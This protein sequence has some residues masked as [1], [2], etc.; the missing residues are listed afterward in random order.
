MEGTL[1]ECRTPPRT[2][3]NDLAW[4]HF[5]PWRALQTEG[6][7]D[8]VNIAN[9]TNVAMLTRSTRNAAKPRRLGTQAEYSFALRLKVVKV[10]R[11]TPSFVR[12]EWRAARPF[13]PEPNLGHSLELG[14]R[15]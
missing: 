7:M 5:P 10:T 6:I 12:G 14:A 2:L 4:P 8:L 1:L 3:F 9:R 11:A 13:V 15:L